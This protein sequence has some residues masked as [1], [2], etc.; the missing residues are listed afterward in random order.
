MPF[1][2]MMPDPYSPK[3]HFGWYSDPMYLIYLAQK[4]EVAITDDTIHR[5]RHSYTEAFSEPSD[6]RNWK[7]N[8]KTIEERAL[9]IYHDYTKKMKEYVKIIHVGDAKFLGVYDITEDISLGVPIFEDNLTFDPRCGDAPIEELMKDVYETLR[10]CGDIP[11][12]CEVVEGPR[13]ESSYYDARMQLNTK[14]MVEKW[15]G[16][17]LKN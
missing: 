6:L 13:F 10:V 11:I 1:E 9:E 14:I 7:E 2:G 15:L 3:V 5:W 17:K 8:I 12:V 4:Y 16:E